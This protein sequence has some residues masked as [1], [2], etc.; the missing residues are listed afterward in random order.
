MT[1]VLHLSQPELA[2]MCVLMLRGAQTTGELA[3]RAIDF[4]SFPD[5]KKSK[6]R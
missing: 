3:G 6:A 4:M 2:A 1:D 5:L